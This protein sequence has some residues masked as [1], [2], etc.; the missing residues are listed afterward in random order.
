MTSSDKSLKERVTVL[1]VEDDAD[2]YSLLE[3]IV[4]SC[5]DKALIHWAQDGDEAIDYLFRRGVPG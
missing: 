4:K 2:D 5:C 1:V 3:D